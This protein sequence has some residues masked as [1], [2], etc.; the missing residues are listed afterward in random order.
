M[1][2]PRRII[3]VLIESQ[4][5][6]R[7]P[8]RT[9]GARSLIVQGRVTMDGMKVTHVGATVPPGWHKMSVETRGGLVKLSVWGGDDFR[10]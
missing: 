4:L 1:T 2:F 5:A 3:D 6:N 8:H 9:R 7:G 10:V